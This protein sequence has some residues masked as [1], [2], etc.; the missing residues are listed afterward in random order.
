[1][2][3]FIRLQKVY[4][5]LPALDAYM[6]SG[7]TWGNSKK[8]IT[9]GLVRKAHT[10]THRRGGETNYP[11]Q[12]K[13]VFASG[14]AT[15]YRTTWVD[16]MFL[17]EEEHVAAL[18]KLAGGDDQQAR[19]A[20][21]DLMTIAERLTVEVSAFRDDSYRSAFE[22]L[23]YAFQRNGYRPTLSERFI[24]TKL[25][26]DIYDFIQKVRGNNVV[27]FRAA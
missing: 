16:E 8:P 6:R 22:N 15:F 10:R 18:L 3:K 25:L 17:S 26:A 19:D 2:A 4:P 9:I 12:Y 21:G 20:R 13:F 5:N 1:M 23:L 7:H 11:E 24:E 27:A 14:H